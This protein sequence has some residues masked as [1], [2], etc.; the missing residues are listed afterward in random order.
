MWKNRRKRLTTTPATASVADLDEGAHQLQQASS[1]A[2]VP[3]GQPHVP[4]VIQQQFED[5]CAFDEE[6]DELGFECVPLQS[7]CNEDSNDDIYFLDE[8][9]SYVFPVSS[10]NN[11]QGS[12]SCPPSAEELNSTLRRVSQV[13][14][15]GVPSERVRETNPHLT[16]NLS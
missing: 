15:S 4:P 14:R 8:F 9:G 7:V 3:Y 6:E 2:G 11:V 1:L 12:C 10:P 13:M 16:A 5:E